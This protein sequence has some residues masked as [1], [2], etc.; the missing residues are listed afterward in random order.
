MKMFF[1]KFS[2]LISTLALGFEDQSCL[3][4]VFNAKITHKV[5]LFSL[6]K[7]D[8]T[9][10]KEI[11]SI[12]IL[13]KKWNLFEKKWLIDYCRI[14]IHIKY[15]NGNYDVFKREKGCDPSEKEMS[16]FCK[17]KEELTN[18]ISNEGLIFADGLKESIST[19]HGKVYCVYLLLKSYLQNGVIYESGSQKI[20]PGN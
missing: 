9:I 3:G 1:F 18:I 15:G 2:L 8:L 7:N 12:N 10:S 17:N 11:C 19:D 14:P 13:F 20:E 4:G 6:L 16:D 5:G